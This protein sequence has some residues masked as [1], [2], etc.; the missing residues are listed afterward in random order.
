[1]IVLWQFERIRGFTVLSKLNPSLEVNAD[2]GSKTQTLAP[3]VTFDF[4]KQCPVNTAAQL[5]LHIK[6]PN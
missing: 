4:P 6:N 2:L 1:M 3:V 5:N